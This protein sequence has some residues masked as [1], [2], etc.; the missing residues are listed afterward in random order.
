MS[1]YP[2]APY[3]LV[4]AT[5]SHLATSTGYSKNGSLAAVWASSVRPHATEGTEEKWI[6]KILSFKAG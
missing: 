2:A 3:F 4:P 5:W 1:G 6:P